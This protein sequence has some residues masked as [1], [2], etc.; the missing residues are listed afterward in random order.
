MPIAVVGMGIATADT[1]VGPTY[2]DVSSALTVAG[3]AVVIA[4]VEGHARALDDCVVERSQS[5]PWGEGRHDAAA[6]VLLYLDCGA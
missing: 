5:A 2:S 1:D 4:S 3:L 6:T